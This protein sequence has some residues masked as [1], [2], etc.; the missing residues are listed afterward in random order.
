[1]IYLRARYYDPTTAQFLTVDPAYGQTGARYSYAN[2][3]PI[4][5]ADPSGL[6]PVPSGPDGGCFYAT[7]GCSTGTSTGAGACPAGMMTIQGTQG[8]ICVTEATSPPTSIPTVMPHP[9]DPGLPTPGLPCGFGQVAGT[10]DQ[11]LTQLNAIY[12]S[13]QPGAE[14][15]RRSVSDAARLLRTSPD[16]EVRSA[17][18][19]VLAK[20]GTPTKQ[21]I[22]NP[23]IKNA[24]RASLVAG[25]LLD[26][27]Q[28]SM[29]NDSVVEIVSKT[30]LDAAGGFVGGLT[31][32]LLAGVVCPAVGLPDAGLATV[33]CEGAVGFG[34]AYLGSK[35]AAKLADLMSKV[36]WADNGLPAL[37]G[38]VILVLPKPQPGPAPVTPSGG[39]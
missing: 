10:L 35:G 29:A 14:A 5:A 13:T 39:T 9:G 15:A 34:G 22:T 36:V 32:E 8:P 19:K 18:G 38:N 25:V 27:A 12:G 23:A 21:L 3:D 17:A 1:L 33:L 28:Y 31:G 7:D 11:T 24:E 2:R 4:D 26:V 20:L 6:Y 16:P 37:T 30:A